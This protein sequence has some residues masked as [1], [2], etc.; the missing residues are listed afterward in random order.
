MTVTF[1]GLSYDCVWCR[2]SWVVESAGC[3]MFATGLSMMMF[4]DLLC[5]SCYLSV[6]IV[7]M[8]ADS[9][10]GINAVPKNCAFSVFIDILIIIVQFLIIS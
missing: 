10:E 6:N 1:T 9:C 8:C 2:V 5:Y 4:V 3:V 7:A